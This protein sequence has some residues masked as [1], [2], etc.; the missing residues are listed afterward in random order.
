MARTKNKVIDLEKQFKDE[1]D[2]TKKY[3]AQQKVER[4][5]NK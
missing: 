5:K 1:S 3:I 4:A 2:R